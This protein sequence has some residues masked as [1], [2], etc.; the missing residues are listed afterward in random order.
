MADE[1]AKKILKKFDKVKAG[2]VNW[3]DRWRDVGKYVMP[4]KDNVWD[5]LIV[6][7]GEEKRVRLYDSS[8]EHFNVLLASALSTMLINPTRQWYQL[9]TDD[10]VL[11][12]NNEVREWLQKTA[13]AGQQIL[14][15]TNFHTQAHEMFLDLGGFGTAPLRMEED[16]ETVLRFKSE[17]IYELW[18]QENHKGEVD[19]IY[20]KFKMTVRQAKQRYGEDI[21]DANERMSIAQDETKELHFLKVVLPSKEVEGSK[22]SKAFVSLELLCENG[23]ERILKEGGF[24]EFPY[25]VPRW[26]KTSYEMYG[27]SPSLTAMPDIKM[28]NAMMQ[29]TIRAAQKATTPPMMIPDDMMG[30]PVNTTPGGLNPYRAGTSDRIFPLE[31]G[32][33]PD[34]GLEFMRD[35]RERIKAVYFIDQ[36]QL[37]EGPQMTATEVNQRVDESL[38]LLGPVLAR[39]HSEFLNPVI[40]RLTAVMKRKKLLPSLPA[41]LEDVEIEVIYNSQIAGAQKLAEANNFNRFVGSIAPLI[42]INPGVIDNFDLDKASLEL[43]RLHGVNEE[44]LRDQTETDALREQRQQTQEQ[45]Q[46]MLNQAQQAETLNE[47]SQAVS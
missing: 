12:N 31:T 14:N 27:R 47:L 24:N 45:E 41:I 10:P 43:A 4:R 22:T 37:R 13:K 1:R 28:I 16:D 35:I 11:N 5:S 23:R 46:E 8:A 7:G 33:R 25:A 18:V 2:R 30:S 32:S 20:K 29:D 19:G 21:F 36:L 17:P 26:N 42:Q 38:R 44:I 34:I 3:E 15:N 9:T 40:K 6:P 39:L